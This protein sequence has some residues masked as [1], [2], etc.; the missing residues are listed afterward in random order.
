MKKLNVVFA[1][2]PAFGLP[3]LEAILQSEHHL[4]AVYTQ[5]DRPAGRG[6]KLQPSAVKQ[7]ALE[8]NIPVFQPEKLKS[9]EE[10]QRLADLKP[11]VMIVVAYGLLLPQAVLDIP[12]YGCIN[13]HAS[14]LPR[15]RGASPIQQAIL[16][17][18][19]ESGVTIMKMDAGLDTG[20]SLQISRCALNNDETAASL[21]DKL[22]LLAVEPL[23]QCLNNIEHC[24]A[25]AEKQEDSLATLAPKIQKDEACLNWQQSATQLDRQI[26][27]FNPWPIAYFHLGEERIRVHQ[28]QVIN[29]THEKTPGTVLNISPEGMLV[30]CQE[31][32][33]LIHKLQFPGKKPVSVAD[34]LNAHQHQIQINDCL[35]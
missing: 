11:D 10:H 1:G 3:T 5:P 8:K 25:Q 24:L 20:D 2:T 18:D 35:Q 34:W 21:H 12:T 26:R 9:A 14:I 6:R 31:Q 33:L 30:A 15:W 23:V 13:V 19:A 32:C 29:K 27:A 17:G 4:V 28:A 7:W 16:H 22:S